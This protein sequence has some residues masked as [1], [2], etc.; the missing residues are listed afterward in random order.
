MM[1]AFPYIRPCAAIPDGLIITEDQ[2][3]ILVVHG[4][5]E[6]NTW[7]ENAVND[8]SAIYDPMDDVEIDNVAS[9]IHR[10]TGT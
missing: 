7:S 10:I 9:R 2:A 6:R 4:L 5:I 8:Y 1:D 3:R